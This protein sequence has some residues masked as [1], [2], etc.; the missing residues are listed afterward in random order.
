MLN[1]VIPFPLNHEPFRS[2]ACIRVLDELTDIDHYERSILIFLGLEMN[3]SDHEASPSI[4]EIARYTKISRQTVRTRLKRLQ[5]KSYLVCKQTKLVNLNGK[6]QQYPN[7]Y[8][9]TSAMLSRFETFQREESYFVSERKLVVGQSYVYSLS[10]AEPSPSPEVTT[11]PA[12]NGLAAAFVES[13]SI[14]PVPAVQPSLDLMPPALFEAK[15]SPPPAPAPAPNKPISL[16]ENFVEPEVIPGS[17]VL[18]IQ[19]QVDRIV[20]AWEKLFKTTV[21]NTDRIIFAGEYRKRR[22]RE[23][24]ML[25]KIEKIS[26]DPSLM[27]RAGSIVFLF[28]S[29]EEVP[30][31]IEELAPKFVKRAISLKESPFS[32]PGRIPKDVPRG[33]PLPTNTSEIKLRCIRLKELYDYDVLQMRMDTLIGLTDTGRFDMC[34]NIYKRYDMWYED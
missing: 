26:G 3:F 24:E 21:L 11:P 23:F 19:G 33:R 10:Y 5:E 29:L 34:L 16:V 9:F 4:N 18:A 7:R 22:C 1:T 17:D 27:E 15:P 32:I 30:A 31:T 20:Q 25:K 2:T 28:M 12:P 6:L 14:D 13:P 8:G